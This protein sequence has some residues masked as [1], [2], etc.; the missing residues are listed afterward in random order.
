MR[1]GTYT[2]GGPLASI[3]ALRWRRA[4]TAKC[5]GTGAA[6]GVVVGALAGGGK[7]TAI[8]V[9]AGAGAGALYDWHENRGHP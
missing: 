5:V 8:R 3:P 9:G 2:V 6:G 7:G 1:R 4:K